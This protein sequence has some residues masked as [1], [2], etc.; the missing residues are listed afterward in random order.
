MNDNSVGLW[1]LQIQALLK[2]NI[3]RDEHFTVFHEPVFISIILKLNHILQKYSQT[4]NRI[5]FNDDIYS[6]DITDVVKKLRDAICHLESGENMVNE[7]LKFVFN[8][9]AG[10]CTGF[11]IGDFVAKSDYEDDIAFFYGEYRIYLIRHI[12]RV[13]RESV[14]VARKLYPCDPIISRLPKP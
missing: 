6:G 14:V 2:A 4:G 3:F 11:K 5:N 12:E 7:T 10:K 1:I 9:V 8:R 13:I